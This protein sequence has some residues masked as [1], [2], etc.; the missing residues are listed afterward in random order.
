MTTK[1]PYSQ[2]LAKSLTEKLGGLAFVLPDGPGRHPR[3]HADRLRRRRRPSPRVRRD[4]S[5]ANAPQR[6]RRL[7][8]GN[9]SHP[10]PEG[11]DSPSGGPL[12]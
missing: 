10:T 12:G 8:R 7:G 5:L 2:A 11:L 3:R 4:R 9:V 1:Y 6:R